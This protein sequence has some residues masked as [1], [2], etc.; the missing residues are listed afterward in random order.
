MAPPRS[1]S[2]QVSQAKPGVVTTRQP[3]VQAHRGDAAGGRLSNAPE[4]RGRA[5]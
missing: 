3:H 5:R 2:W 4:R 1:R